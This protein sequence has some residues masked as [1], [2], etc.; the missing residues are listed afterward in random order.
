MEADKSEQH[1]PH[2]LSKLFKKVPHFENWVVQKLTVG[3]CTTLGHSGVLQYET[4]H[5]E[6][7]IDDPVNNVGHKSHTILL[8]SRAEATAKIHIF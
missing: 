3:P 6:H 5:R 7:L 1:F 2:C 8:N 4:W